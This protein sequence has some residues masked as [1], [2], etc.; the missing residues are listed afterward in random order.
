M[1]RNG[2]RRQN[3]QG[4]ARSG[5]TLLAVLGRN[6]KSA[7]EPQAM[8]HESHNFT[9]QLQ[10]RLPPDEELTGLYPATLTIAEIDVSH[11]SLQN[12]ELCREYAMT[13]VAPETSRCPSFKLLER[14]PE[15]QLQVELRAHAPRALWQRPLSLS[16][17]ELSSLH[18]QCCSI[19]KEPA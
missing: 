10:V 13:P 1:T 2:P 3:G 4:Q 9:R 5:S 18:L 7:S 6:L 15:V 19:S 14:Q 12:G 16:F 11:H 8:A 17:R